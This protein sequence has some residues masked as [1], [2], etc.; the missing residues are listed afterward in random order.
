MIICG[1]SSGYYFVFCTVLSSYSLKDLLG[2]WGGFCSWKS[3]VVI[4]GS[5][6]CIGGVYVSIE[7]NP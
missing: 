5:D 3:L 4:C 1:G 2:I 7:D 6:L